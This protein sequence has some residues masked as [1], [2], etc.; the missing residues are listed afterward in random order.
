MEFDK[1][2]KEINTYELSFTSLLIDG[3]SI[4]GAEVGIFKRVVDGWEE[5]TPE[6][7]TS[8]TTSVAGVQ[9][10]LGSAVS[11][12]TQVAGPYIIYCLVNTDGGRKLAGVVDLLVHDIG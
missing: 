9:I 5:R 7:V 11:E 6:F 2:R 3:E 10:L 8:T 12:T 4:L 1:Y